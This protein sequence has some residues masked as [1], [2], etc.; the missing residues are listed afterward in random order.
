V[1]RRIDARVPRGAPPRSRLLLW[2][3]V[4]VTA[5]AV[6]GCGSRPDPLGQARE[7]A[8][9]TLGLTGVTY[10]LRLK[11]QRL[12][13]GLLGGR[14][15]Y[16]LRSGLGYE[17]LTLGNRD[18]STRKLFFDFL[19]AAFYLTPYPAPA[20]LLP[21]GKAWI[22]VPVVPGG[23]PLASQVEGLAPELA[24]SEIAWGAEQA[25]HVGRRVVQHVP[26]DEYRVTVDLQKALA[27]AK[28]AGRPAVA[29]AIESEIR[30][31]GSKRVPVTVW[32]NGPGYVAQVEKTVPGTGL[33]TASFSLSS[34]AARFNRTTPDPATIVPLAAIAHPERSI[35]SR[36]SG[37]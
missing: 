23:G 35:W 27:R 16:D 36:A 31:G 30:T 33:G 4:A 24:L 15:A 28:H 13:P 10:D 26:L 5:L 21:A 12:F 37:T 34:F 1:R 19:P 2:V 11:G 3:V 22:S 20:G 32:V 6:A 17:A 25:T 8:K 29:A 14:A 7:A 9:K 18:G